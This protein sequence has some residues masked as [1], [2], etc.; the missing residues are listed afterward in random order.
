[1]LAQND[2]DSAVREAA[3]SV[4]QDVQAESFTIRSLSPNEVLRSQSNTHF[5]KSTTIRMM[6]CNA[7]K[8]GEIK[9]YQDNSQTSGFL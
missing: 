6:Y 3:K 7:Y 4:L 9:L 2:E 5:A 8:S 1:M